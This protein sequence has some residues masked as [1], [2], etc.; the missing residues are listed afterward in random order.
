MKH[1]IKLYSED[2]WKIL[3]E[4]GIE[5]MNVTV[6]GNKA[7]VSLIYPGG[8]SITAEISTNPI[9]QRFS[10]ID[11]EI[12]MPDGRSIVVPKELMKMINKYANEGLNIN[13]VNEETLS[14][15][16]KSQ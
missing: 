5:D 4:Y 16:K 3:K 2:K 6:K 10:K 8:K 1:P 14:S 15:R 7:I 9:T 11:R 12:I 13:S